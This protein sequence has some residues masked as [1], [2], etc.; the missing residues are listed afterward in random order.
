MNRREIIQYIRQKTEI[1]EE[2]KISLIQMLYKHSN[3]FGPLCRWIKGLN[4]F[5]SVAY[6]ELFS[7]EKMEVVKDLIRGAEERISSETFEKLIEIFFGKAS[8]FYRVVLSKLQKEKEYKERALLTQL[9][10]YF[11]N[12]PVEGSCLEDYLSGL[13]HQDELFRCKILHFIYKHYGGEALPAILQEVI[14]ITPPSS[15]FFYMTLNHYLSLHPEIK[16]DE[17]IRKT[18]W[19]R[20]NLSR[21][22]M[23]KDGMEVLFGQMQKS[24]LRH[25]FLSLIHTCEQSSLP[26]PNESDREPPGGPLE[27]FNKIDSSKTEVKNVS[28]HNNQNRN[29]RSRNSEKDVIRF[30]I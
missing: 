17:D 14:K 18:I 5:R 1:S 15:L 29:I 11:Y 12:S 9:L 13:H 20:I 16:W 6:Q 30:E 3:N 8:S 28:F 23:A 25:E 22:Q 26:I 7:F 4:M 19:S 10:L 2:Q 24:I 27:R 21:N